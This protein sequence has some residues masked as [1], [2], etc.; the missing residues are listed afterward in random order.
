MKLSNLTSNRNRLI[1][2]K[3]SE[4]SRHKERMA[5]IEADI[6]EL[7]KKIA[8]K[9]SQMPTMKNLENMGI[10]LTDISKRSGYALMTVWRTF[11]RS[12]KKV[13]AR[14]KKDILE[15]AE[16]LISEAR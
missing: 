3:K 7:D 9:R 5:V 10:S 4:I 2:V 16:I 11:H 15:T 13:D 6:R 12:R 8:A 1:G 14:V